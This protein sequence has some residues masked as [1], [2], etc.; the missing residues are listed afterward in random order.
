MKKRI[1]SI[2]IALMFAVFIVF[3]TNS[4]ALVAEIS[5]AQYIQ[6]LQQADSFVQVTI[7]SIA[8]FVEPKLKDG[9]VTDYEDYAPYLVQ[10]TIDKNL[11]GIPINDKDLE[12]ILWVAYG[13]TI[14]KGQ[15]YI[16][17]LYENDPA[18]RQKLAT[19]E[20]VFEF[21]P[22]KYSSCA[23]IRI[24]DDA[25]LEGLTS[26]TNFIFSNF[27]N[28]ISQLEGRSPSGENADFFSVPCLYYS[29]ELIQRAYATGKATVYQR[30]DSSSKA[31]IKLQKYDF[32]LKVGETDNI[33]GK[34][35]DKILLADG[36]LGYVQQGCLQSLGYS[37]NKDANTLVQVPTNMILRN[38]QGKQLP[39]GR[40][41]KGT[42]AVLR[43]AAPWQTTLAEKYHAIETGM[44]QYCLVEKWD[45]VR[46]LRPNGLRI[47]AG[48]Y[49]F[50]TETDV[51][52]MEY[53][54]LEDGQYRMN[55]ATSKI[56]LYSQ[57]SSKGKVIGYLPKNSYFLQ[58]DVNTSIKSDD[59]QWI[60]IVMGTDTFYAINSGYKAYSATK[61]SS[62]V[63]MTEKSVYLYRFDGNEFLIAKDATVFKGSMVLINDNA[64]INGKTYFKLVGDSKNPL[65][66]RES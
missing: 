39:V 7:K 48:S 26:T 31:I 43:D 1:F 58:M 3:D 16:F 18:E 33:Y 55:V 17:A 9:E 28:I 15:K 59:K 29:G 66:I 42:A 20:S 12:I 47:T 8:P 23:Q 63:T 14:S 25:T 36:T 57:P 65:W 50:G 45:Y 41:V 4:S 62:T 37:V 11:Y 53:P 52:K 64:I 21:D 13:N 34:Y 38:T 46:M 19:S 30:R 2:C 6:G 56:T 10:V 24:K 32:I 44:Q 61:K 35:W 5:E 51:P 40:L 27:D 22:G 49:D 60:Q 54:I